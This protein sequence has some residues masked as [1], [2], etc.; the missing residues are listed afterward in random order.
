MTT[1]TAVVKSVIRFLGWLALM[2]AAGLIGLVYFAIRQGDGT[3]TIDTATAALIGLV[4]SGFTGVAGSL[5]A[6]LV[7]TRSGDANQTAKD[8]ERTRLLAEL[9][10]LRRAVNVGDVVPEAGTPAA[11]AR[12][13]LAVVNAD[14]AVVNAP[15]EGAGE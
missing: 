4:A 10:E 15:A 14:T 8:E 11:N 7:S 1:D 12:A 9:E 2:L 6:L 3:R 13:D 5:G